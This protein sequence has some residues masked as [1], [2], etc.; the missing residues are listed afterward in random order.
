M[1]IMYKRDVKTGTFKIESALA[2][3]KEEFSRILLNSKDIAEEKTF[4]DIKLRYSFS[5]H[6]YY[7]VTVIREYHNEILVE[8]SEAQGSHFIGEWIIDKKAIKTFM[9]QNLLA[10]SVA[11]AIQNVQ[12]SQN[13]TQITTLTN[14]QKDAIFNQLME[15]LFNEVF[16]PNGNTMIEDKESSLVELNYNPVVKPIISDLFE[17][18]IDV[19]QARERLNIIGFEP[20][21]LAYMFNIIDEHYGTIPSNEGMND[22]NLNPE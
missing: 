21:Q 11:I 4:A 22:R 8:K 14:S 9:K 16:Q 6:K 3:F 1:E 20:E 19:S 17:H 5:S 15:S 2:L 13:D 12:I 10:T 7:I 18:R